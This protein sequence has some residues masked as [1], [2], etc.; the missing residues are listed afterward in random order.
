MIY[1]DDEATS[2]KFTSE[3]LQCIHNSQQFFVKY[4]IVFLGWVELSGI[5]ICWKDSL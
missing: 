1:K 2:C 5:D 3:V 4:G